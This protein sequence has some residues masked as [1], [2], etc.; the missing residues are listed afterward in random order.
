MLRFLLVALALLTLTAAAPKTPPPPSVLPSVMELRILM[1]DGRTAVGTA[2]L[3]L[4]EGVA[5]TAA[6][7]VR[8]AKSVTARF[9]NG[10]EFECT[11]LIDVDPKRNVALLRVKLFGRPLLDLKA[12]DPPAGT[13]VFFASAREE[14]FGVAPATLGAARIEEG[15]KFLTLTPSTP[16]GTSG[17]P[18]MTATGE[19]F[20]IVALTGQ[21]VLGLPASYALALDPTL[22]VK[23]WSGVVDAGGDEVVDQ[24]MAES[25]VAGLELLV[26][27]LYADASTAGHGFLSGMPPVLYECRQQVE[28]SLKHL[29]GLRTAD[30]LRQRLMAATVR[31]LESGVKATD[32]LIQSVVVGQQ[33]GTWGPTSADL[34][35]RSRALMGTEAAMRPEVLADLKQLVATSE[36]FRKT[37]PPECLYTLGVAE[38]KSGYGLAIQAFHR[39]PFSFLVVMPKGLGEALGFESGDRLVSLGS[40]TWTPAD[41]MEDLRMELKA[42]LGQTVPAVVERSGK[43]VTLEIDIPKEI[44]QEYLIR[45]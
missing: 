29:A 33:A 45:P 2:F 26:A 11:G 13:A 35:Q 25:L 44:P 42:H 37:F 21:E 15:V 20:G 14:G 23:P 22:S 7:L 5:V 9:A 17:G 31:A 12:L 18:L 10:E 40:R 28:S 38:R 19:V 24:R 6:H 8:D 41:T 1:P 43:T 3:A 4:R 16:P 30:P 36:T 34:M 32:L 39:T 27:Y